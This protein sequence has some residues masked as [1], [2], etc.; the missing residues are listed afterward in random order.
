MA[1]HK[2]R[3]FRTVLL[4]IVMTSFA[5]GQGARNGTAGAS[6]LLIPQGARYLSGGGATA[7]AVGIDAI[8]WNPAGLARAET[9]VSAIF[10]RRSY[11]A[12]IGIN[13]M[14]VGLKMGGLGSLAISART[15][16]VGE[17][18]VTD[19][20]NPDGTGQIFEPAIFV[21]G[22]TYSRLLTDRTSVGLNVSYI[23]E[24]FLNV[25]ATG[26]AFDAGIQYHS[27]LN[28]PNLSIGVV[29]K[30]FGAA[31]TYTGPGLWVEAEAAESDRAVEWYKV[32]AAAFD[33][34][35]VMDIGAN[36]RLDLGVGSLDLGLTFENS[37]SA[38][39]EYR[40]FAQFN[41]G[42]LASVRFANMTAAE[43]STEIQTDIGEIA[44]EDYPGLESIFAS[45]SFGATLNL[46][47]LTGV[48]LSIDYAFIATEL[49]NDNQ[50]FALRLDL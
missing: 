46:K 39:D 18:E 8:Y 5:W 3:I 22:A 12:D 29:L 1:V 42:N 35:F 14:G 30:N 9:N 44:P 17:I 6:Q 4:A 33:M 40:L 45:Y 16:D 25:G 36:Y 27:F 11:I 48:G 49:F 15:F 43:A 34:P 2:S 26:L 41:L 50:V 32:E 47:P 28:I 24:E 23:N 7:A 19:V 20:F 31:M 21:I 37:G 13:F 38:Q 10:S